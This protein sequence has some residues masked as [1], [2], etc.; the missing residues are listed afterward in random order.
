MMWF[1]V[2]ERR[3]RGLVSDVDSVHVPV[4][5]LWDLACPPDAAKRLRGHTPDE[6]L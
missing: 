6:C 4:W 1:G 3:A 2:R 5:A